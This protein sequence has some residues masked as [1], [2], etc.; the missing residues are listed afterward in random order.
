MLSCAPS[1]HAR[2]SLQIL[3]IHLVANPEEAA[4]DLLVSEYPDSELA[5]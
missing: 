1:D 4:I 3:E 5:L 2:F